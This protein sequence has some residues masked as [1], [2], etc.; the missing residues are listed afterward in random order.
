MSVYVITIGL[1]GLAVFLTLKVRYKVLLGFFVMSQCFDLAPQIVF[2]KLISDLGA[3][4]LLVAATQLAFT[5]KTQTNQF[6]FI[7]LFIAIFVVWLV[8]SLLYSLFVF[9]YPLS[10]TLKTSR[11]M[12]L[13]YLSFFIFLRLF[14]TDSEALEILLKWLYVITYGLLILALV[15]YVLNTPL[16]FGLAREYDG[17]VRYLPRFLP[18]CLFFLWVTFSKYFSNYPIKIHEYIYVCLTLII[19]ATTYTRGIYIAVLFAFFVMLL[20]LFRGGHLKASKA[21]LFI[22]FSFIGVIVILFSGV[23]DRVI[24]RAASGLEIMLSEKAKNT[25]TD[26]D[27]FSGR[28]KLLQERT[29]LVL[30]HN[31]IFGYGFIHEENVPKPLRDSL[32]YGSVIQSPEMMEKYKRGHPYVLAL[33]SADIGWA[34]IVINTGIVGL[35]L[36][37]ILVISFLANYKSILATTGRRFTL[38]LAFYLQA[39]VLLL[40]MFNGNTFTYH[41]QIPCLMLAGFVYCSGYLQKRTTVTSFSP[42]IVGKI[43]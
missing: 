40:L 17:V 25:K 35:S 12:I 11:H 15:Q 5:R 30:S 38:S 27:T 10:D 19:T 1:V 3:A 42:A 41:V 33:Y 32:E 2:G 8:A 43:I 31:P 24:G 9:G 29:A 28:W 23:A 22:A 16:L 37:I 6:S 4:M 14:A 39:M 20:L 13:G 36:F 21:S 18:I 34:N 7:G 26:I